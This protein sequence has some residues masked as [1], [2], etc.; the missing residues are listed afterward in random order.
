MLDM[1]DVQLITCETIDS[2]NDYV[3]A[4]CHGINCNLEEKKQDV[5]EHTRL[6]YL[7]ENY[8]SGCNIPPV[9]YSDV[10]KKVKNAKLTYDCIP[11]DCSDQTLNTCSTTV[12]VD[13]D[14]TSCGTITITI[15]Q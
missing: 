12:A 3:D 8:Q 5:H 13:D 4:L 1:S 14:S 7:I 10:F 11:D 9:V 2:F 6:L 15:T